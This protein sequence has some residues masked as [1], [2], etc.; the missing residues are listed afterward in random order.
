MSK[1]FIVNNCTYVNK[2]GKNI[3]FFK[4][5]LGFKVFWKDLE[6]LLHPEAAC[7]IMIHTI[8]GQLRIKSVLLANNKLVN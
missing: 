2:N 1:L 4:L 7:I 5:D 6:L 8:L 3:S